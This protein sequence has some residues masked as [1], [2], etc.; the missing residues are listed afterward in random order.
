MKVI[1]FGTRGFPEVQGGVEVHCEALYPLLSSSINI[2]VIRRTP[3]VKQGQCVDNIQFK[4]LPS[5]KIKGVEALLH[6]FLSTIYC[7]MQR[8]DV[9]HIHN[10]GPAAFAPILKLFGMKVV[11]TYHSPNYEHKKWGKVAQRLLRL[12]ETV[13][14]RFS[15]KIIFV[16]PVQMN[17]FSERVKAKSIHIPNGVAKGRTISS[18]DYLSTIGIE[19][20][21]Y[22]LAVGRITEEK[23][24]DYLIE[25]FAKANVANRKL[26][27]AGAY[28]HNTRYAES[29]VALA[30]QNPN[31]VLAGFVNGEPLQQLYS[32]A[33][34]FILPSYNEG[35]P[36]VLL[37]AMSYHLQVL[38]SDIS[39]NLLF[40]FPPDHY[41]KTGCVEQ[42]STTLQRF[43]AAPSGNIQYN[44]SEYNWEMIAIK[45]KEIY[46]AAV[47]KEQ[48]KENS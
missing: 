28:D 27:I 45:T 47:K 14:L 46:L 5:T 38:A 43:L 48:S 10:I 41:F 19:P 11:L 7:L 29:V 42:L 15:D 8:P 37:E 31:V 22:L 44:L 23:G 21:K 33:H 39:P 34:T 6:S 20:K 9:V 13:A 16:N 40:N 4:D 3:Y 36:L 17:K 24:F 12:S 26:V 1:V 32:H 18:T 2:T 25:A 35:F 30:K